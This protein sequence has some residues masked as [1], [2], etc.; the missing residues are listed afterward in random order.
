MIPIRR[1]WFAAVLAGALVFPARPAGAPRQDSLVGSAFAPGQILVRFKPSVPRWTKAVSLSMLRSRALARI[2]ALD[3][4]VVGIDEQASVEEMVELFDRNPNVAYAQP[5]YIYR[6]QVTPNDSLFNYQYA[7]FNKG[8]QIGWVPGS[9][10]GSPNADIKAP[11]GW[12]ETTGSSSVIIGIVDTGI[13][14]THPDLKN[15]IVGTGRDF[16][17]DDLVAADDHGHGTMVAGVAGAETD[18][19]EGI[20]GVGWNCRLLPVKVLDQ[21][22]LGTEDRIIQGLLWAVENGAKVISLSFGAPT[23]GLALKDAIRKVVETSGV[24]VIAPTGNDNTA[25]YAPASLDSYVLAVAATDHNDSRWV[26][27][28]FG[29]EVDVAAPGYQIFTTYPVAFSSGALPYRFQDGTSLAAAHVA[30]LAG[31]ILSLKPE[32]TPAEVMGILRY[33]ADDVN[34]SLYKGKDEYIGWGRINMEK[35]LVPLVVS[36]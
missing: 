9:P 12:E 18:N 14:L 34:A 4:Y 31:L 30:G 29:S 16:V 3:I 5:N 25:V 1:F 8:Q 20:A 27:S 11:Q 22:G 36:K 35:A 13:D 15:K 6:A 28:N 26:N 10:V 19:G 33:S 7:L 17:N 32:L 21:L 2:E 24:V 23:A